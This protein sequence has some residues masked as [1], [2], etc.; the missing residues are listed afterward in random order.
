[1][2]RRSFV[3]KLEADDRKAL[4]R[5]IRDQQYGDVDHIYK[6]VKDMGIRTSRSAIHRYIL[7]LKEADGLDGATFLEIAAT[8]PTMANGLTRTERL[9]MELGALRQR[10]SEVLGELAEIREKTGQAP[11]PRDGDTTS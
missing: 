9:L 11:D 4:N 7:A 5:Y 1:M 10:E 2:G 3:N 8:S 6:Y